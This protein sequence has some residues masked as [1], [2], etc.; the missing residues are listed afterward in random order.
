MMATQQTES[1]FKER[2]ASRVVDTLRTKPWQRV[3]DCDT[4][5]R[6]FGC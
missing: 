6:C 5:R 2:S 4:A 1:T 3:L